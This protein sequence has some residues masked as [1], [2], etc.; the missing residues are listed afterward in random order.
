[1]LDNHCASDIEYYSVKD[2]SV[3]NTSTIRALLTSIL[4]L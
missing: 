3:K 4:I 2:I 1:M